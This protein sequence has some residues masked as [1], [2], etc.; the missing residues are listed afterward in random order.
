MTDNTS[1]SVSFV[2]LAPGDRC[3]T[4][5]LRTQSRE[6]FLSDTAAG[7]YIVICLVVTASDHEGQAAMRAVRSHRHL[8]DDEFA[9]LFSISID[10]TDE[11]AHR[12]PEY[13]PGV[14][15]MWDFER[16]VSRSLGAVPAQDPEGGAK[17]ARR[18]WLVVAPTL[19]I[20]ATIPFST[21]D[22]DHSAVFA[23]LRSLP[24]AAEF[25]GQELP[26]PVLM[27][28]GVFEGALCEDLIAAYLREGGA[29]SG[30]VRDGRGVLDATFKRRKDVHVRDTALLQRARTRLVR[31]VLP[32]IERLFFMKATKIERDIVGCYSAEDGGHFRPHRDNSPGITAHRRFAVSI[33]LNGDFEGGG[34]YFPE[35]SHRGYKAPPG[36]ALIFPCAILHAVEPVTAGRRYAYLPF[37]YDETGEVLRLEN[38]AGAA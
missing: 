5:E 1:Q 26:P 35:Y 34:V 7:R 2:A 15:A 29:E 12:I 17:L 38:R 37:L 18:I 25:G 16:T 32:E 19:H 22:P 24:P 33:N 31:R 10:P 9:S 36:W 11:T 8:F 4:F 6:S 23:F 20:L 14:R 3:P 30:F 21:Q 27:L 28:P 13:I